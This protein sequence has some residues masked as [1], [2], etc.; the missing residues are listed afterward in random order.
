MSILSNTLNSFAQ[1]NQLHRKIVICT[2]AKQS[3]VE[4]CRMLLECDAEITFYPVDYSKNPTVIDELLSIGVEVIEQPDKLIPIIEAADCAIEDGARISKI[5]DEHNIMVRKEFYSV[6]QTPGGIRYFE[7]NAPQYPVINVAMSAVKLHI[8]NKL[9]TPEGVL[10]CF[11]RA[12]GKLLS[13]KN[14]LIIGYGS[15]GEGL[16]RLAQ[17]VGAHVTVYDSLASKRLFAKHQGYVTVEKR[18]L[19]QCFTKQDVIFMATNTYQGSLI[20]IEQILLMRDGVSICNAGSGRGEITLELQ[21]EGNFNFHDA[22]VAISRQAGNIVVE[23]TKLGSR[24]T[25]TVLAEAFP[26]NLH[27]GDGTSH[28]A[29]EVVMALLLLALLH[30]PS[31]KTPGLQVLSNEIQETVAEIAINSETDVSELAP[32]YIKSKELKKTKKPYGGIY[33]FHNELG[34]LAKFSVARAIFQPAAKTRGHCHKQTQESYFVISGA[35]NI[36]VWSADGRSDVRTYAVESGDY[37]LVPENYFHDV[38]VTSKA[39]FE[40]LVIASPPFQPW[41]QFFNNQEEV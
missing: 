26:I 21:E 41:D 17:T 7:E 14:I 20:G 23:C 3:S 11:S 37:L 5:I 18:E 40:C 39:N 19:D 4:L 13:G 33:P 2:H 29:I 1:P 12:T 15:I 36:L 31:Q 10:Q 24:K 27:F 34:N 32:T 8:E 38:Q 6:E 22:T 28:D 25:V 9:A 35:A 16:A 30:G